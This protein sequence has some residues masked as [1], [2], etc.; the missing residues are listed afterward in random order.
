MQTQIAGGER[1]RERER[2]I[3]VIMTTLLVCK[4]LLKVGAVKSSVMS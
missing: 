4:E 1:E 3:G 2:G